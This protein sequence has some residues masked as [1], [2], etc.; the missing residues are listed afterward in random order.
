MLPMNEKT[1]DLVSLLAQECESM[2]DIQELLK[3]LFKGTIEEMLEAEMDEHLGYDKHS[4]QG[5]L[6]GNSRNGYNKKT[7][8]TQMGKS[9]IKVPRDR[10]S[11]F[12]PQLIGKYQNK[13]ALRMKMW[14]GNP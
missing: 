9:E 1:K 11:K 5:D 6:T 2:Q 12:E 3:N 8:Q 14:A 10:N 13:T 7:I 4:P